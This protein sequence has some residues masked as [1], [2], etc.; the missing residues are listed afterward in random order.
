MNTKAPYAKLLLVLLVLAAVGG[1]IFFCSQSKARARSAQDDKGT[2]VAR[3]KDYDP[4]REGFGFRNYGRDHDNESDLDAGDLIK[5]FGPDGV[6]QSGSTAEDCVLYEPAEEW[7]QQQFK[8]LANGHCDG[9]AIISLRFWLGLPF[10]GR[11]TPA[12]WQSGAE[13]VSSL[14]HTQDI[15]NYVAYI[16]VM[17]ALS[18]IYTLRRE[19]IKNK[20]SGILHM[21]I[22]S[23]KD[24]AE[25]RLELLIYLKVD[26]RLTRGHAITPYAIED[27][28]DGDYRIHVYDS[29]F[30]NQGKFVEMNAKEETWRYHTASDPSQTANDYYGDADSHSITVQNLNAREY[31]SYGCPF[32]SDGN[33][34]AKL[35]HA[36]GK[37]PKEDKVVFTM[38]GEGEY[39]ITDPTGKR[40]GYDFARNNF[41]NEIPDADVIPSM[42]GLDKKVPAQYHLPRL[43]SATKPY[44]ITVSGKGINK[45]VDADMEMTGPGFLVGFEGLLVD[46]GETMSMT[47]NPNGR[48]LSF[49]A[50]QDGETPSVF[51]TIATGRKSPS[52][53]FEIGGIKLAAGKTVTLKLD[54]EKQK[55]F[56]QDNDPDR[57]PYDV[58]VTRTNPN[59]TRDF[60]EHDNLDLAK[61]SDNYEMDFSKWTPE[62]HM[63][64]EEDDEGNGFDD[65]DCTEEPN[66]KKPTAKPSGA[67]VYFRPDH[68]LTWLLRQ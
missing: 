55:L 65:E 50:S 8:M 48:E 49:T 6:C 2:I 64:F 11:T 44:T 54:L 26:G 42:G 67:L 28:G 30:P 7:L 62:G 25:D 57:D 38:D 35:N 3:L 41:V 45:E 32:C 13:H 40:I 17:Q 19:A 21:L 47:I 39:I 14:T 20:P 24:D 60:Y 22:D 37:K 46:P 29:N 36:R 1:S 61:K 51:I 68:P 59:G 4:R 18:E 12:N 34:Q 23:M 33:E 15:S 27:M 53:E 16:H 52:Y 10:E 66:E 9:L 56:F 43:Q 58:F 63:C 5:L 31:E